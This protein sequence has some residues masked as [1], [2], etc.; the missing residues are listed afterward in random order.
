MQINQLVQMFF[1]PS[2]TPKLL[3]MKL[4]IILLIA[5]LQVNARVLSQDKITITFTNANLE[6]V[7]AEVS[8]QS[9]FNY[10]YYDNSKQLT[11]KV[12]I[13]MRGASLEDVLAE[14]F[15][16]QP[17]T[18]TVSKKTHTILIKTK[19]P[20]R[21]PSPGT[22]F[23]PPSVDINGQI[24]NEKNEPVP[25]ASVFVNGT[26]KMTT[27]DENGQFTL[28][29]VSPDATITVRSIGF[30]DTT[31]HLGGRTEL[32]VRLK[33]KIAQL[34]EAVISVSTGYQKLPKERVTGSF[35]I[36]NNEL[37]NKR[38]SGDIISR[39]EGNVSGMLFNRNTS[40]NEITI[41]GHSTLFSD[42]S[43]LI[44]VDNF[45]YDGDINSL[46]PNDI[47]SVTV[48]KD[49]AAASIWGVKSGNGVIVITT[50]KGRKNQAPL[51]EVN[52]NTSI[53]QKINIFTPNFL[54]A[55]AFIDIEQRLFD[56]H[57]YDAQ[58]SSTLKPPVSPVV[59]ILDDLR[60]GL[61]SQAEAR[62]RI[63]AFRDIDVRSDISDF[64]Y[65]KSFAQQYSI[66][67]RGGGNNNEYALSVGYDNNKLGLVGNK[68]DRVT[69]NS[70]LSFYPI[71]NLSIYTGYNF[72]Q[73]HVTS[74]SPIGNISTGGQYNSSIYPYAKLVSSSGDALS[75]VKDYNYSWITDPLA[76]NGLLDWKYRPLD[77]LKFADNTSQLLDNRLNIGLA[78]KLPW[79]FVVQAKYQYEKVVS[80]SEK[81]FSDSTYYARNLINRYTD[82]RR[83]NPQRTVYPIPIGGIMN[84]SNNEIYSHR[85]RAEMDYNAT[86]NE[87]NN[88]TTIIGAEIN[89]T[90]NKYENP[91]TVYGYNKASGSSQ[92]VNFVDY[93]VNFPSGNYNLIPNA[94]SIGRTTDRF[95]S[96]F[97]NAA[98]TLAKKYTI[99]A[100]GRIDKSNLFGVKTNQQSVPLYSLGLLWDV[101]KEHFYN[102][103]WLQ[104]LSLRGS[105]G[106][107]GNINKIATAVTTIRQAS[108]NQFLGIPYNFVA[109]PGNRFLK[110]EKI[111][112]VNLGVDFATK[113]NLVAGSI[114]FYFKR[115]LDL[116][117]SSPLAPSTGNST[118]FG[119][120]A[121]TK[122][123]GF[124]ITLNFSI[125][126]SK[127]F[128]WKLN[129]LP[130]Y[131]IDKVASYDVKSTPSQYLFAS[132]DGASITPSVG[133]PIFSIY[134]YKTGPLSNEAGDP[135]G[136]LNG[137]L[138]TNYNA[139]ISAMKSVDS[140]K[141]MGSSRPVYFGSLRNSIYFRSLSLSFNV[142]YKLKYYFRR[143]SIFY[144][145]LFTQWT[146]H[147]DY[148]RRWVNP[149]D[150]RTTT[151]PSMP[152]NVSNLNASRD[153]FYRFSE[154]LV[155]KGDHIRLQDISLSYELNNKIVKGFRTLTIYGYVSNV[156]II[157]KASNHRVDPDVFA[158][159]YAS[160]RSY[161]I[162]F[163]A[164]F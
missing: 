25:G 40:T 95:V 82:F 120:T 164:S 147:E 94:L 3:G 135:Q 137:K 136:Y 142:V 71:K 105:Y 106:Y 55:S 37:F 14:C 134:S 108:N 113:R 79:G 9:G 68:S 61:I 69:L 47:E 138:S 151:V 26:K 115:G 107:N 153:A 16:N 19:E 32:L 143:S 160:P 96:Y 132:A 7:L 27:A 98:Y 63:D 140:L 117:G 56:Q 91:S 22:P 89:Q 1:A 64:F 116:F 92:L 88:L 51:I 131:A 159:D 58:L 103:S 128:K 2:A 158:G 139:I 38:V 155:E 54:P 70:N 76:Q 93:Y 122:G 118:F 100:S 127:C 90:V 150:E 114:E 163:K 72:S 50:K 101:T 123:H 44:V 17:L 83:S 59:Q 86:W 33:L 45:P 8:R 85:L 21:S 154:S 77:E 130:S 104:I 144:N 126:N 149:G 15:K 146:G 97:G 73:T 109:S 53:A 110:W 124:D 20:A 28:K 87:V 42:A 4:S 112:I 39:L 48:L 161:S 23:L 65:R 119:N 36:V 74:N 60:K 31:L 141:Y 24:L 162:G 18:F 84:Q 75:I 121:S 78:Y 129:F 125:I 10:M 6:D 35:S 102:V 41:R 5:C 67:V 66:G 99:Y 57:F 13:N 52:A 46:N 43:P 81:Y 133:K 145:S 152:V 34:G 157:W 62:N 148:F 111:R 11:R 30:N 80:S 12:T 49:A 29:G 156:G